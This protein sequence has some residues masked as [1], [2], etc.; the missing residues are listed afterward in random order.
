MSRSALKG[1]AVIELDSNKDMFSWSFPAFP[2]EEVIR[3]RSGLEDKDM[4]PKFRFSK[5]GETWHYTQSA[6]V[7][8]K[9]EAKKPNPV[10]SVCIVILSS[11]FNP[12]KYE[13]LTKLLAKLY[14]ES[15]V[16]LPIMQA[17]LSVMMNGTIKTT[18]G[19]FSEEKFPDQRAILSPVKPIF[20]MFGLETVLIWVAI[21]LKKRVLVYSEDVAQLNSIIRSFPLIGGFHR[22]NWSMLR[23]YITLSKEELEDLNS[24]GVYVAGTTDSSA[25]Q[26]KKLYDLFVDIPGRSFSIPDHA[27]DSFKMSKIHKSTVEALVKVAATGS[28]ADVIKAINAKTQEIIQK[29]KSIGPGLTMDKLNGMKLP[30]NAPSFLYNI[31]TAE[32]LV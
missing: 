26:Q 20:E 7:P 17:Y 15:G 9:P 18:L 28:D 13:A 4:N 23:P 6:L 31:A 19:E 1:V 3:K 12:E 25:A 32:N 29:I 21:L 27:K 8:P 14:L 2:H 30:P 11:V 10:Q 16:T 22:R 5:I 24:A